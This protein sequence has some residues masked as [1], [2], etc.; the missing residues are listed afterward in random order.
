MKIK[1]ILTILLLTVIVAV[2][3]VQSTPNTPPAAPTCVPGPDVLCMPQSRA[4]P[5]YSGFPVSQ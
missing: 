1:Q 5:V 4:L 2:E 3:A